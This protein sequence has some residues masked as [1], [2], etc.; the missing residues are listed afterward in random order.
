MAKSFLAIWIF[1]CSTV[2][3]PAQAPPQPSEAYEV[4]SHDGD[5][6]S[7]S[8]FSDD[9]AKVERVFKGAPKEIERLVEILSDYS[10]ESETVLLSQPEKVGQWQNVSPE[11]WEVL[12]VC[13]QWNQRT[14]GAFDASVGRL[15]ILCERLANRKPCRLKRR[16]I[17]P[18][19]SVVG[20]MS[21]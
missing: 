7:L 4:P 13:D 8:N 6:A 12:Q 10:S 1:A 19:S 16:S 5:N 9:E 20:S 14:D 3:A 18:L 15:S 2:V 21:S 11:L 17:Q